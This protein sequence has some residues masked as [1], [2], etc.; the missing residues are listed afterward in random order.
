MSFTVGQLFAFANILVC[1]SYLVRDILWLRVLA[2][3]AASCTI[4]YFYFRPE[5][6]HWPIF[7]QSAFIAINAVHVIILIRER[8][9]V[10]MTE[11]QQ[12][13]YTLAFRTLTQREFLRLSEVAHWED[14]A[15][16][17]VLIRKGEISDRILLV[18]HGLL[19]VQDDKD[20]RASLRDGQFAGEMSFVL[21][22]PHSAYVIA[23]EPTRYLVWD[24]QELDRLG[25]RHPKIRKVFDTI[26]GVD[27]A[28]KLAG[29]ETTAE[30]AVA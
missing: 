1:L 6:L 24:K 14:A 19:N 18:Y 29:P 21:R 22:K 5:V 8:M 20:V 3:L 2:I 9:P 10:D 15:P 28:E 13:L 11:E 12:R 23:A 17:E 27:M 7:W 16:R 4:P 26:V 25:K 30:A